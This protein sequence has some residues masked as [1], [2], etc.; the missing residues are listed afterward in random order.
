M[1]NL[2]SL[3]LIIFLLNFFN[4]ADAFRYNERF[5][6]PGDTI[7]EYP[8]GMEGQAGLCYRS[9]YY[10]RVTV[11]PRDG[12]MSRDQFLFFP[13]RYSD[14][15]HPYYFYYPREEKLPYQYEVK[16]AGELNIMVKPAKAKVFVDGYEL[17]ER[18]A[19]F[20]YTMGLLTGNHT[21][22]ICAEG[23]QRY[24]KEVEI[25]RG[26]TKSLSVELKSNGE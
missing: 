5:V 15:Y 24:S 21:V 14:F 7:F 4:C 11:V 19:D 10:P 18:D 16:P 13:Y 12:Y 1:K 8:V 6:F 17:T 3:L 25:E 9:C 2:L 23:Y 26:K 22:E 20:S